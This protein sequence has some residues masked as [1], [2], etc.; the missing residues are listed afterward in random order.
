MMLQPEYSEHLE[1]R[2]HQLGLVELQDLMPGQVYNY[3]YYSQQL[4]LQML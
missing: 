2:M 3:Y 4:L 1:I